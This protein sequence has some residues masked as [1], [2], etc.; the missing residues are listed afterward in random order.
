MNQI[1]HDLTNHACN[2]IAPIIKRAMVLCGSDRDRIHLMAGIATGV[3]AMTTGGV[4]AAKGAD[5][6]PTCNDIARYAQE[7]A[8]ILRGI[9]EREAGEGQKP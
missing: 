1:T 3:I 7:V 4:N 5:G 9:A 6:P 2:Q 8:D